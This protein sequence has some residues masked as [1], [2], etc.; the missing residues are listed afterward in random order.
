MRDTVYFTLPNKIKGGIFLHIPPELSYYSLSI[1][2]L[3]NPVA[4]IINSIEVPDD[5]K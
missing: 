4:P 2:S 5:F 3:V 1:S